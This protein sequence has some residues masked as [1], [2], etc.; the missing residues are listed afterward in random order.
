[1]PQILHR[2]AVFF[3]GGVIF[4]V[5]TIDCNKSDNDMV[6]S[7]VHDH[8]QLLDVYDREGIWSTAL[9]PS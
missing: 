8:S 9:L 5:L 2:L 3:G 1:M 4:G 6:A 7:H